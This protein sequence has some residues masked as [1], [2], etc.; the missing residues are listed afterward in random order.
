MLSIPD[1]LDAGGKTR[2]DSGLVLVDFMPP[3]FFYDLLMIIGA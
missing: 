3:K 2:V 1:C